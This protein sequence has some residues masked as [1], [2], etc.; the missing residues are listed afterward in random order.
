METS[1]GICNDGIAVYHKSFFL[2]IEKYSLFPLN[3]SFFRVIPKT[4]VDIL[5]IQEANNL[6]N[7]KINNTK[8]ICNCNNFVI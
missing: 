3:P 2:L 8:F 1:D 6:N 5:Q 7:R 4:N